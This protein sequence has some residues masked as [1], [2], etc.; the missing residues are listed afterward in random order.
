MNGWTW[1]FRILRAV[2]L[3]LAAGILAC[4][5]DKKTGPS[6]PPIT[7]VP[8]SWKG[9]WQ[10]HALAT[11]CGTNFILEDTT[12]TVNLCVGDTIRLPAGL[13]FGLVCP[14]GS[15]SATATAIHFSCSHALQDS[16]NGTLA[17]TL[18]LG[19]NASAGTISGTGR[20]NLDRTPNS[21]QCQD[22]CVNLVF[23][24]TRLPNQEPTCPPAKAEW[25]GEIMPRSL[26]RHVR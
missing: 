9:V 20:V 7:T 16:C 24:G 12:L 3:L 17:V 8:T 22:I 15:I 2:P 11:L 19:I 6:G 14:G 21:I 1:G 10:L 5:S 4:G 25:L 13:D 18:D 23:S 26:W